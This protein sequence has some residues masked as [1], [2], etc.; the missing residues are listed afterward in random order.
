MRD[1]Q[2][3]R[4]T[5]ATHASSRAFV[6]CKLGPRLAWCVGAGDYALIAWCGSPTI[7]LWPEPTQARDAEHLLHLKG[8]RTDCRRAHEVVHIN[9]TKEK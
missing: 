8:C 2:N 4:C 9:L 6:K 1:W 7:T 3:C 5:R